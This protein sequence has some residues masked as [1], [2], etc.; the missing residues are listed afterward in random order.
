M[1]YRLAGKLKTI[2]YAVS[3]AL[4]VASIWMSAAR[5]PFL[6][7]AFVAMAAGIAVQLAFYRCPHCGAALPAN[8]PLPKRCPKCRMELK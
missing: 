8:E 7:G 6:I 4:A 2:C 3:V 1:N 5:T